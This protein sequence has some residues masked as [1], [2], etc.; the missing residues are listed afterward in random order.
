MP[1]NL[2][3]SGKPGGLVTV[4]GMH[5]ISIHFQAGHPTAGLTRTSILTVLSKAS[6]LSLVSFW[7]ES[8]GPY[9][10]K[11]FLEPWWEDHCGVA[12]GRSITDI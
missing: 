4:P 6:P 5:V 3:V 2:S 12:W 11:E 10:W 9:F 1:G 7:L 8:P